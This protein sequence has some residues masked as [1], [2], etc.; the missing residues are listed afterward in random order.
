MHEKETLRDAI[1]R[2]IRDPP[3]APT[4]NSWWFTKRDAAEVAQETGVPQ[5]EV[6]RV[7]FDLCGT[8]WS[9]TVMASK[10][11]NLPAYRRMDRP[12]GWTRVAFDRDWMWER[13]TLPERV[14]KRRG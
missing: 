3:P 12:P 1:A 7:F 4:H 13:G 11:A 6:E 2:Y 5:E 9:G 8:V 14:P 10:R